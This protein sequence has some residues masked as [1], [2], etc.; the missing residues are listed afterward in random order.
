MNQSKLFNEVP[1]YEQQMNPEQLEAIRHQD[2]PCV[3]LAQAGSGKTRCLVHR[4]ARLIAQG[5]NEESI[6]AVTFA[7]KAKIEM[8]NRLKS[9][10]IKKARVGTW[11]SLCL[12]IIQ[13]SQTPWSNWA[14]DDHDNAKY[15]LKDVLGF[16]GIKWEDA[17]L[18]QVQ[19]FIG[20][21]KA[22][23]YGS[24]SEDAQ[25]LAFDMF[26]ED[27]DIAM[28][29][30]F[31]YQEQLAV[32]ALL[33]YDDF[34]VYAWLHMK[35][36]TNRR[37]WAAKWRYIL[38]DEAQDNNYAQKCLQEMLARD[39]RNI[40]V[41]GDVAQCIPEGEL[42]STPDGYRAIEMIQVGDLVH[43][44]KAG[45]VVASRVV[46]TSCNKKAE[47]FEFSIAYPGNTIGKIKA[48]AEHVMFAAI[49][50]PG[51]C[52]VY[53]MYRHDLG[54]RIGVSRTAGHNGLHFIV[55]T[56]QENAE[57]LWVLRWF[58]T[59]AEAAELEAEWA[60]AFGIP[61]EPF[62]PRPDSWGDGEATKRLFGKFGANGR[63][64]LD[65]TGLDFERPN[66][67][68]KASKRGRVAVNI[69]LATKDG[70]RVEVDTGIADQATCVALGMT[71][72][73]KGTMRTRRCFRSLRE[74]RAC[75]QQIAA[76]LDGYVT[77][78]LSGT[79]SQRRMRAVRAAAV[80]PGME[81]PVIIGGKVTTAKVVSRK[82]VPVVL[83]YD[84]EIEDL[85]N[86]IVGG[87]VVH[88][89]IFGFRGSKP[90]YLAGFAEEWG[91]RTIVMNRNYRSGSKIVQVANDIIRRAE[92]RVDADMV[93]ERPETGEV[94]VVVS[95]DFDDEADTFLRWLK[96]HDKLS[97][98]TV[99]YRTNAQSRAIEEVL[100]SGKI[101][102]V[103]VGGKG[104][105]ERK[106]V[107]DVLAYVRVAT[108]RTN[109]KDN[110]KRC[111]NAPFR[112]LGK[113]FIERVLEAWTD[114]ADPTALV[115]D[116]ATQAGIQRRQLSSALEWA[117]IMEQLREQV[118]EEK[119]AD[120][121]GKLVTRTQYLEWLRKDEGEESVESSHQLN[122]RELIRTADR[123]A[124]I[125]S[126]L[127]Y[128][129]KTAAAAARQ[130][131]D[132]Q[133]GGERVLLMTIHRA[134][135]L[136]WPHLFVAGCNDLLVPHIRGEL[137][138]ER[139]LMYV[140][141][142]RARDSLTLSYV[143]SVARPQGIVDADPSP[144]LI[145]AG[146]LDVGDGTGMRCDGCGRPIV[147]CVCP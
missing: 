90:D 111:L 16:K 120:V 99:L 73:G 142:T 127:D 92:Y 32:R 143:K 25:E 48:T 1:F 114:D 145:E 33:T 44:V 110:L 66:Y 98:C 52:F 75:A 139:R 34:L 124:T 54:Y 30:Y 125:G 78:S 140:A 119:P 20:L 69:L 15:I 68:A 49:S 6:L 113:V 36:E 138:E 10:G 137:E 65:V 40:M 5:V 91:A 122:I 41:V 93:A 97:D 100:I 132:K 42:I 11:H 72:S 8:E 19:R 85:G 37:N 74:A 51:G 134:K 7:R 50:D 136:E 86:F 61:R 29:A 118:L 27:G 87:V 141:V 53:L 77:E 121:L 21:C 3:L 112:Y 106:E 94:D 4:V 81:L 17:D 123:F 147:S 80:H 55:R 22:N 103:I 24:S 43:S 126:L 89:S 108:C 38:I 70:H 67:F 31:K 144:F 18:G 82:T 131:K 35:D 128:I 63:A 12:Q 104:F 107:R 96:K 64:L 135:G 115:R 59:Y 26:D 23:L 116:V 130:R 28:Q 133:A 39:H 57:R 101:P 83:T 60:Y 13:E 95:S 102:Y 9:L 129:D 46:R 79:G 84:L 71:P 2:G 88:N 14:I 56:Q 105:Y 117:S 58:S 76:T 45:E 47:A 62:V 146:L 109:A